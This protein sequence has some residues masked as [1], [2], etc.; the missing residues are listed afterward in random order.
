MN[1][2][3]KF[4]LSLMVGILAV[5]AAVPLGAAVGQGI[6]NLSGTKT[7]SQEG[8]VVF[9]YDLNGSAEAFGGIND[10]AII[11]SGSG[12]A[13]L[14]ATEAQL[15][16]N[17]V[18]RLSLYVTGSLSGGTNNTTSNTTI[19]KQAEEYNVTISYSGLPAG[20]PVAI[21]LSTGATY[22]SNSSSVTF[23]EPNGTYGYFSS[24]LSFLYSATSTN[25]SFTVSGLPVTINVS[26]FV[27]EKL[28]VTAG[29]GTGSI[30]QEINPVNLSVT[31]VSLPGMDD[32]YDAVSLTAMSIVPSL[33]GSYAYVLCANGADAASYLNITTVNLRTHVVT[34]VLRINTSYGAP[35]TAANLTLNPWSK[36]PQL[37]L[38]I[39]NNNL[40][41]VNLTDYA[42][43]NLTLPGG[44]YSGAIAVSPTQ[45]YAYVIADTTTG[46]LG[47]LNLSEIDLANDSVIRTVGA[48]PYEATAPLPQDAIA[49]SPFGSMIAVG[50]SGLD[51]VNFYNSSLSYVGNATGSVLNF[52]GSPQMLFSRNSTD[53][54]YGN[55]TIAMPSP[56]KP[57]FR[58]WRYSSTPV[59]GMIESF[60]RPFSAGMFNDTYL[61]YAD[62]ALPPTTYYYVKAFDLL[63]NSTVSVEK[64]S[65]MPFAVSLDYNGTLTGMPGLRTWNFNVSS[66]M[67]TNVTTAVPLTMQIGFGS[68]SGDFYSIGSMNLMSSGRVNFSLNPSD[69]TGNQSWNLMVEFNSSYAQLD[70]SNVT[71]SGARD[72]FLI[73]SEDVG[74]AIGGTMIL[75]LSAVELPWGLGR[76]KGGR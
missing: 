27:S 22:Y 3:Q 32:T 28:L 13:T 10:T 39:G 61:Y 17:S 50:E 19:Q 38:S 4:A 55:A 15:A 34:H 62:S 75:A 23:R 26:T 47:P 31:N 21:S 35:Q 9:A 42:V 6:G 43:H 20:I 69:F 46:S 37:I 49:V 70:L 14:N 40:T 66:A 76:K 2:G 67:I 71:L 1:K 12:Y 73:S 45:P 72:S 64:L 54:F 41:F 60:D 7:F 59:T 56:S 68:S 8:N 52:S 11:D 33:N 16:S 57:S 65:I 29:S 58:A 53:L 30:L 5:F 48:L 25:G 44:A 24:P 18:D 74:Y 63:N 51:R 36:E